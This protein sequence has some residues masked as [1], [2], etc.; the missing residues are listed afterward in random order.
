MSYTSF[1]KG[2]RGIMQYDRKALLVF[3]Q[4]DVVVEI[5]GEKGITVTSG[6]E[7]NRFETTDGS[8]QSIS[9]PASRYISALLSAQ[10]S[11]A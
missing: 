5:D 2:L 3:E 4:P 11:S 6:E 7:S 9:E 8:L 1:E 10:Q